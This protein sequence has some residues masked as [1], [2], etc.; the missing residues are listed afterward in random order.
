MITELETSMGIGIEA[1]KQVISILCLVLSCSLTRLILLQM[2][3]SVVTELEKTLFD[4]YVKPRSSHL[5]SLMRSGVLDGHIDWYDTPQPKGR[6]LSY[7][8][9]HSPVLCAY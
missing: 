2:L 9:S 8:L 6:T 3:M 7:I 4:S 5:T 1:E